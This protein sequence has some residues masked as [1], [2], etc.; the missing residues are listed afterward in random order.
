MLGKVGTVKLR[1]C[2]VLELLCEHLVWGKLPASAP[3][4]VGSTVVVEATQSRAKPR[5][6][7]V[8][9]V[10]SPLW[11]DR[12]VPLKLINPSTETVT[13]KR[14]SKIAD[15]SPATVEELSPPTKVSVNMQSVSNHPVATS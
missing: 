2:V 4:S 3:I 14:N 13:L 11:G 7:L 1:Q 15:V 12:W 8:G 6:M 5:N 10:I 9:R